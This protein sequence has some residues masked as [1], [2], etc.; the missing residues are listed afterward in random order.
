[1]YVGTNDLHHL[2]ESASVAQ[3]IINS[4]YS[5]DQD[6]YD[7]ALMRLSKPLTLSGEFN[8]AKDKGMYAGYVDMVRVGAGYCYVVFPEDAHM[9]NLCAGEPKEIKKLVLKLKV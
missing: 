1:M 6:D 8:T 7:I 2:P 9:P 3:I 4:N 5:D